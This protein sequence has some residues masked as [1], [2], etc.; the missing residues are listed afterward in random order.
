MRANERRWI[1]KACE[2]V[3]SGGYNTEFACDCIRLA[4]RHDPASRH[5]SNKFTLFYTTGGTYFWGPTGGINGVRATS[6]TQNQR[7]LMLLFF[8]AADGEL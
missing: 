2:L 5:L 6:E 7:V 1:L 3:G 8:L 4:A